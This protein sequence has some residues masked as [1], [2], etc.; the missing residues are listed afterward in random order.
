M[1]T[2]IELSIP[3]GKQVPPRARQLI[4]IEARD[5]TPVAGGAIID[6]ALNGKAV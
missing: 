2:A 1:R 5:S 4:E 3:A 6:I